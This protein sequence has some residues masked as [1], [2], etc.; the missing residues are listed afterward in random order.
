MIENILEKEGYQIKATEYTYG[1][2]GNV[3]LK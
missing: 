1:I 2:L 3:I